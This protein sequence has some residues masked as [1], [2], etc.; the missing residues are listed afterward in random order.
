MN[1]S[2]FPEVQ[3][4]PEVVNFLKFQVDMMFEDIR[5]LL[6]LPL[7]DLKA[8]CN[9]TVSAMLFNIIAGVS[10]CFYD[11]STEALI[12][13]GGRGNRFKNM[14]INYY[15]W[16]SESIDRCIKGSP[17][18]KFIFSIPI[19]LNFTKISSALFKSRISESKFCI[20]QNLQA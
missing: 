15:P 12:Q 1:P 4:Y 19:S 3:G 6:Q 8:G 13:R 9:F 10:V 2:E 14:L 11:A 5:V 7:Y 18:T 17:P 20:K 16:E